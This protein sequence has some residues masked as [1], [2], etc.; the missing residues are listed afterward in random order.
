MFKLIKINDLEKNQSAVR[1]FANEE[2][3][4]AHIDNLLNFLA[5]SGYII[6]TY[7]MYHSVPNHNSP[8][9]FQAIK[10]G[11]IYAF[12]SD[13]DAMTFVLIP[14]DNEENVI[15]KNTLNKN[16]YGAGS[17]EDYEILR[18]SDNCSDTLNAMLDNDYVCL[19][20]QNGVCIYETKKP[21]SVVRLYVL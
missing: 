4:T 10:Q 1:S 7:P 20:E 5:L 21:E 11:N 15:I 17:I 13:M 19:N 6:T 8:Q 18:T 9:W 14:V 12:N 3:V 16:T 2:D